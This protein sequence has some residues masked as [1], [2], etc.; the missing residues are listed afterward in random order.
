MPQ[1]ENIRFSG[2]CNVLFVGLGPAT[3]RDLT[4][5]LAR[6]IS[7]TSAI[8]LVKRPSSREISAALSGDKPKFCFAEVSR[9]DDPT[10]ELIPDLLRIDPKVAIV[11][12]LPTGDTDLILRCLRLGATGFLINPLT[13]AQIQECIQNLV[14]LVPRAPIGLQGKVINLISAKGACGATTIAC[15]L[16]YEWKRLGT[17]RVLL[18]DLDPLTGMVS[19]LLKIKPQ[20]SFLDILRRGP[21]IDADLWKSTVL[22]RSGVDVLAAPESLIG[23]DVDLIDAGPVLDYAREHYNVTIVDSGRGYGEWALSQASLS[24]EVYLVTTNDLPSIQ[25]AQRLLKYLEA[26]QIGRWKIRLLVNRHEPRFGLSEEVI[27]NALQME[28]AFALPSEYEALQRASLEGKQVPPSNRLGK[29]IAQMADKMAGRKQSTP[30]PASLAGL[31][32]I[33]SRTG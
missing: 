2:P 14:K 6:H 18:A 15:A 10:L 16:S 7:L 24:D 11:V 1:A 30:K 32:S 27:S 3:R 33:F 9:S 21:D 19:F 22:S 31:L 26:N 13:A 29:A 17:Q 12:I 20:Y 28:I 23:S 5:L 8:D 25:S 4:P